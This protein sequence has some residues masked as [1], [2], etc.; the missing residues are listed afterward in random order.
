MPKP[1]LFA[2]LL[3]TLIAV[4]A[5]GSDANDSRTAADDPTVTPAGTPT[6]AEQA[7]LDEVENAAGLLLENFAHFA[8]VMNGVFATRGALFGALGEAGAGTAFDSG[9]AAMEA[10]EPPERFQQR[11]ASS[12]LV[13]RSNPTFDI[14]GPVLRLRTG[15]H[16]H[17]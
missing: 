17:L 15:E 9:L 6:A 10:L 11:V 3:V 16:D 1:I 13:S 8:E 2:P 12:N 7:Y 14:C 5:C 4:V